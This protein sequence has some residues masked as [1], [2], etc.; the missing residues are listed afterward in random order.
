MI[1][2]KTVLSTRNYRGLSPP[3]ENLAVHG[4]VKGSRVNHKPYAQVFESRLVLLESRVVRGLK[5][6]AQEWSGGNDG[7]FMRS[8]NVW[9]L[10][11]FELTQFL[12]TSLSSGV[13]VREGRRESATVVRH[14]FT[15]LALGGDFGGSRRKEGL[16]LRSRS[17]DSGGGSLRLHAVCNLSVFKGAIPVP[18]V[19]YGLR[20]KLLG[21][22][23]H[24]NSLR[25]AKFDAQHKARARNWVRLDARLDDDKLATLHRRRHTTATTM[26]CAL[27]MPLRKQDISNFLNSFSHDGE[28]AMS[29]LAR[30]HL[31]SRLLPT[32]PSACKSGTINSCDH[33]APNTDDDDGLC[34]PV[35]VPDTIKPCRNR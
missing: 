32:T 34:M 30:S 18:L 5:I 26:A 1:P 7:V 14:A 24:Q 11:V 29:S 4:F 22:S 17:M 6:S 19:S 13:P 12:S 8:A 35:T 10:Q 3:I 16:E 33:L 25:D 28:H 21:R 2:N 15:P 31:A 20:N 23:R 27:P 9:G